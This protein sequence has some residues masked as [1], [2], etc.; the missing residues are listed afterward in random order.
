MK[1]SL[2]VQPAVST[3]SLAKML[4]WEGDKTFEEEGTFMLENRNMKV[5]NNVS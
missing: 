4:H 2:A 1:N 5:S 3:S